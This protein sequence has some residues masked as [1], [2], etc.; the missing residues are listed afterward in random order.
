M[1]DNPSIV[2]D[3]DSA[4]YGTRYFAAVPI[5]VM[6]APVIALTFIGVLSAK[7]W[8]QPALSV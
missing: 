6:L 4:F 3:K 5:I 2:S 1:T 7:C 8:W